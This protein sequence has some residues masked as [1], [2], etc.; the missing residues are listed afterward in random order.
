MVGGSIPPRPIPPV[1]RTPVGDRER[2]AVP[3]GRA[4]SPRRARLGLYP[5][6]V[7][8][9]VSGPEAIG[10]LTRYNRQAFDSFD[11]AARRLGW[12]RA[13]ANHEIA[14][15]SIKNTLVH[16]LNVHE[17]LLV[18]AAQ[19]RWEEVLRDPG[20]RPEAVGSFAELARYRSRV[21]RGVDDLL[22]GLTER[23]LA[24][25]ARVPW[26][27]GR[28]TIEDLFYQSAFEQ[29]HHLGEVIGVFWQ[30]DRT[31]PQMMWI[32]FRTGRRASVS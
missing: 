21:W 1:E 18:A 5:A 30:M 10:R 14:H 16:I 24:A 23:R 22:D 17:I 32:P 4:G 31:P 2:G 9:G 11:R 12:K 20:R 15:R 29:A 25:R 28:F 19:D 27:R 8:V 26:F 13:T 3:T 7:G 6:S